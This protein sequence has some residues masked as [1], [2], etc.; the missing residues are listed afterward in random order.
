MFTLLVTFFTF[1]YEQLW[2]QVVE[3]ILH[4]ALICE[5]TLGENFCLVTANYKAN[6]YNLFG[7]VI[8][9][10]SPP[11]EMLAEMI[12]FRKLKWKT[13]SIKEKPIQN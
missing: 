4:E 11:D 9:H 7:T 8:I 2:S 3:H 10:S 6:R 1:I 13:L 12:I 5:K